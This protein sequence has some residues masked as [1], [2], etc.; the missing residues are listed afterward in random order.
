VRGGW[1]GPQLHGAVTAQRVRECA[2]IAAIEVARRQHE[3]FACRI[4]EPEWRLAP[5]HRDDHVA[6]QNGL[7][8][9]AAPAGPVP[10]LEMEG[11][12]AQDR[13]EAAI[14]VER[15]PRRA[16]GLRDDG[17]IVG[18]AAAREELR[19]TGNQRC[20][21]DERECIAQV[22]EQARGRCAARELRIGGHV[23]GRAQQIGH[24]RFLPSVVSGRIG[25]FAAHQIGAPAK[26][27]RIAPNRVATRVLELQG[28]G[29]RVSSCRRLFE[30]SGPDYV[31]KRHVAGRNSARSRPGSGI[32]PRGNVGAVSKTRPGVTVA[33]RRSRLTVR[34]ARPVAE[35]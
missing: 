21:V 1:I 33:V 7:R 8:L 3:L 30:L 2:R 31:G 9:A 11:L 17:R 5:I 15:R 32:R 28:N 4:L 23:P 18:F 34:D 27:Q 26:H 35:T 19:L 12:L 25:A 22:V 13:A 6:T 29:Q 10:V 20:L 14:D 24:E 16:A